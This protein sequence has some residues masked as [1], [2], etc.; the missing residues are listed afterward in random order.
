MSALTFELK[1]KPNQRLDL[2]PLVPERLAGMSV[3]DIAKLAIGT[4][5]ETLTVGDAFKVK[6]KNAESIRF[7]RTDARCDRIG[8]GLKGGEIVVEGNA[9]AYLG[10]GMKKGKIAVT[11]SAGV[12]AGASMSGGHIAI[13]R[14]AGE[15][16]GGVLTGD[17]LGMKGGFLTI[18][19]NAGALVGE[20]MRRGL[21]VVSG[22]AGD[23]AGGRMI[24]GTI[25]L[26]RGAGRYAGYGLRRGSLIFM[27]KPKD[28]LPTFNDCGVL[29]FDYLRLLE[30]WLKGTGMRISLGAKARRLIG[31]MAVLGKGEILVLA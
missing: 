20:R 17:T 4:T 31:D 24:A 23:Y 21:L 22:R 15:R 28:L 25:V 13:G 19:G 7:V 14:D 11:G 26:K 2:S 16:A 27:E 1:A 6:G 9:G 8:A 10:A 5:R 30:K 3:K 12:L 29:E 18:G